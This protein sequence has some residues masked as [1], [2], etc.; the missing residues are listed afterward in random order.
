[1]PFTVTH[2][3]AAVPVAWL[4][5]WRVPFSALAIGAMVPHIPRVLPALVGLPR[6]AFSRGNLTHCLPMGDSFYYV[7]HS[8]MKRPLADLVALRGNDRLRP[9]TENPINSRSCRSLR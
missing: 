3:A 5:R 7:Y 2:V 8:I 1:M 6:D 4:C 9:W